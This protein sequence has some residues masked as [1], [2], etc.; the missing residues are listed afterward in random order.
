MVFIIM[1]PTAVT[2]AFLHGDDY[3]L[4]CALY[5]SKDLVTVMLY[6]VLSVQK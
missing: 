5:E 4:T 2:D 1:R 3:L 6:V